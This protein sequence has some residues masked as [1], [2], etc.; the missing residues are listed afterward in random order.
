MCDQ[1]LTAVSY[2]DDQWDILCYNE[3]MNHRLEMLIFCEMAERGML[4]TTAVPKLETAHCKLNTIDDTD[5]PALRVI[6][7]D[8]STKTFLP[9]LCD[10]VKSDDGIRQVIKSFATYLKSEEGYLWGIRY[11]ESLVGFIAIMDIPE[12]STIFY[13]MNARYRGKGLMTECSKEVVRWFRETHPSCELHSEIHKGN[14]ASIRIL[15]NAGFHQYNEDKS[16][17]YLKL[18]ID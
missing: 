13:A 10:V 7:S 18:A 8:E 16:K 12:N 2:T 11:D 4:E 9:E 17:V 3:R 15:N 5:V 1:C 14:A 6:F